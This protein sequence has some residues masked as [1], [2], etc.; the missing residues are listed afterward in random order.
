MLT[1]WCGESG[2][3]QLKYRRACHMGV[4]LLQAAVR[5]QAVGGIS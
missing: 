1:K 2:A 4:K 5:Q 3:M